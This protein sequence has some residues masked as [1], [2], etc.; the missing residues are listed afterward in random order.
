M[1]LMA[2]RWLL[3]LNFVHSSC[4]AASSNP[5]N[6]SSGSR[7]ASDIIVTATASEVERS[8]IIAIKHGA[9]QASAFVVTALLT[10]EA[11]RA[12][13]PIVHYSRFCGN[14]DDGTMN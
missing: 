2:N 9:R 7:N 14:H 10:E 5:T 3:M 6:S 1:R 8:I 12:V 4:H 13:L 11:F